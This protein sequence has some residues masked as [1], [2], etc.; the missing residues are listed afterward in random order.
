MWL[1]PYWGTGQVVQD[2]GQKAVYPVWRGAVRAQMAP[3]ELPPC[4]PGQHFHNLRMTSRLGGTVSSSTHISLPPGSFSLQITTRPLKH[5]QYEPPPNSGFGLLPSHANTTP[6][7]SPPPCEAS[8]PQLPAAGSSVFMEL[9]LCH[10]SQPWGRGRASL[11]G[12][13]SQT[14]GIY[15]Q[16]WLHQP[17]DLCF[18]LQGRWGERATGMSV[19]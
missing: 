12:Q 16:P 4:I 3:Q 8:A 1:R 11:D 13:A 15:T 5:G 6:H 18:W 19:I 2:I 17:R 10:C 9:L 14:L 7:S